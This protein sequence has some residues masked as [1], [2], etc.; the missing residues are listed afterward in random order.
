MK[1]L[2]LSLLVL[3]VVLSSFAQDQ[4][5]FTFVKVS[6]DVKKEAKRYEKEGWA[7]FAG[8]P[9]IAQQL[10]NAFRKQS[11]T[12]DNGF[13]KWIVANG[14]SKGQTEA[15]AMAQAPDLAKIN[16]VSLIESNMNS[17]VETDVS[18]N[19]L[20]KDEAVSITKT[21]QVSTNSVSKK[22]GVVNPLFGI[23]RESKSTYE[24]KIMLAYN[25]EMVRKLILDEMKIQFQ[26]ETDEVR[27]KHEAYLNPEKYNT[28]VIKNYVD[29]EAAK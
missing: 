24:V 17:V 18:N 25:F 16:L 3:A 5:K 12:D 13:P 19:Q 23:V 21:I 26:N 29:E 20:N 27:K 28:G 8:K 2:V 10:D 6:S 7:V 1:K 22:L 11:E 15:A 14:T 9:P 4:K